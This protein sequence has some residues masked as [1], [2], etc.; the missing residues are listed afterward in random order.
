MHDLPKCDASGSHYIREEND[1]ELIQYF[2]LNLDKKRFVLN[3][4]KSD[5]ETLLRYWTP[6]GCKAENQVFHIK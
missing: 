3:L 1:Q 4:E 5:V 2:D 6:L